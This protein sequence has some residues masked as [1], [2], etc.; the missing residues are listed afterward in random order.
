M[1]SAMVSAA[2]SS[3]VSSIS[4]GV[5]NSVFSSVVSS[6]LNSVLNSVFSS[7]VSVSAQHTEFGSTRST[8][9]PLSAAHEAR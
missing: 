6:I 3:T 8:Q 9:P 1:R 7:V 5:L 2:F 4:P